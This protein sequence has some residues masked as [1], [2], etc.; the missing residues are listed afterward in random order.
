LRITS[1]D[2]AD[3]LLGIT[4]SCGDAGDT[5]RRRP[6]TRSPD[7]VAT[8]GSRDALPLERREVICES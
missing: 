2:C 7:T 6:V 4:L 5:G 8:E 1:D 3:G